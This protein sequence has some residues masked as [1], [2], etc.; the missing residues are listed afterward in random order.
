MGMQQGGGMGMQQGGMMPGR[1]MSGDGG[2]PNM[3]GSL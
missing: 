2:F 1:S 3:Y